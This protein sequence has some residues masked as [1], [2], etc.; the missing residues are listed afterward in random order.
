MKLASSW[1]DGQGLKKAGRCWCDSVAAWPASWH[2][3]WHGSHQGFSVLFCSCFLRT[4]LMM[5]STVG[6]SMA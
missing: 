4:V 1:L 3:S 6:G 2:D 5:P